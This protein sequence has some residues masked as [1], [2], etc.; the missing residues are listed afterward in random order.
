[1][2]LE[3]VYFFRN[4]FVILNVFFPL[5]MQP[6]SLRDTHKLLSGRSKDSYFLA[7]SLYDESK[8]LF[9]SSLSLRYAYFPLCLAV[10]GDMVFFPGR[11]LE[12]FPST[13]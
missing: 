12:P 3:I 2:P 1:M 11:T 6:L 5:Y 10:S 7:D 8:K 4:K 13:T 9:N